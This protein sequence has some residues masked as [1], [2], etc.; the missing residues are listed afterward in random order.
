MFASL[1]HYS[2]EVGHALLALWY[3]PRLVTQNQRARSVSG[4]AH[5]GRYRAEYRIRCAPIRENQLLERAVAARST[6]D[7]P[8]GEA[9]ALNRDDT[10]SLRNRAV[11]TLQ[12]AVSDAGFIGDAVLREGQSQKEGGAEEKARHKPTRHSSSPEVV[13]RNYLRSIK[14]FK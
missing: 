3:V 11:E 8:I 1:D 7:G 4:S 2:G 14:Q 5:S 6:V 13:N 12:W 9:V 10:T